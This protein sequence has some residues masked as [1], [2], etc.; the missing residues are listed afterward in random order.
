MMESKLPLEII[1]LKKRIKRRDFKTLNEKNKLLC[2][3]LEKE[4]E[5]ANMLKEGEA[6][7]V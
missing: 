6:N 7:D 4:R 3:L 2:E 1:K 5:L